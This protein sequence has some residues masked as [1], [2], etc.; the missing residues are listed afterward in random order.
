M[1]DFLIDTNIWAYWFNPNCEEHLNV[2]K[3]AT[4]LKKNDKLWISVITWGEI[5]YGYNVRSKNQRS[6]ETEFRQFVNS[7]TP[8]E[9]PIDKHVTEVYGTIRASLF[10]KYASK[11][12][13]SKI[14]TF[15]NFTP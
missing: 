7:N 13:K 14:T 2:L 6:L 15:T 4:K 9:Y 1:R 5:E 11:T 3:K 10:K 12:K 8:K